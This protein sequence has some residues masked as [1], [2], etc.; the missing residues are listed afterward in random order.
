MQDYNADVGDI[1]IFNGLS[2]IY[3]RNEIYESKN[4]DKFQ[5]IATGSLSYEKIIPIQMIVSDTIRYLQ[6]QY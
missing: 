4:S 3:F 6:L 2:L 1:F 5:I